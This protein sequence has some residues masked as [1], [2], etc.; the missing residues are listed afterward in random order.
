MNRL[1]NSKFN[2]SIIYLIF[3][4]LIPLPWLFP[5]ENIPPVEVVTSIPVETALKGAGTERASDVWVEMINSAKRS[6]DFA[7]F[8]LTSEK[9]EPL[10]PVIEALKGASE[11]GVGIRFLIEKKMIENSAD[12]RA[13]LEKMKNISITV[14]DWSKLNGGIIHA[15][16]F[17]VD[18]KTAY[19]GSQNFDWRALKHIHETG[20]KIMDPGV[21]GNLKK[22][23]E[24]DWK[25][26]NGD[27]K[28]YD[29]NN[30][31]LEILSSPE[32]VLTASP[33]KYNPPGVGSSLKMIKELINRAENKI[34]IQLLSYKTRIYK[35]KD[36]FKELYTVM[37]RA[38]KRGVEIKMAVSDWNLEKPG[39][40]SIKSLGKVKGITLKVFSI[41]EYSKGFIPYARVIHSKVMRVDDNISLVSTS[42]WG[43]GYFYASRNVE[44]TVKIKKI[45]AILDTLFEEL[46]YSEYGKVLDP[47]KEYIPRRT[48]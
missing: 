26:N 2:F 15:K 28:A 40:E 33:E 11:R 44:V 19:I 31:D 45:A 35:S 10:E 23:F 37:K 29:F 25:Y 22:I 13:R 41:P 17:I 27:K 34:T 32:A 16:Y 14:F 1:Y 5:S 24:A 3:V 43:H 20:L 47:E 46:W 6:I 42:N 38:A 12:L 18:D 36:E 48:H 21:V 30:G 8:Y 39:I 9:D 4:F 7:E